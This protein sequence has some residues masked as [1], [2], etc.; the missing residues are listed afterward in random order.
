MK[1]IQEIDNNLN[2]KL[3][4]SNERSF[5]PYTISV[6]TSLNT[7]ILSLFYIASRRSSYPIMK[8]LKNNSTIVFQKKVKIATQYNIN[9]EFA[10]AVFDLF[11][12]KTAYYDENSGCYAILG[13]TLLE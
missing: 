8:I 10:F 9:E 2:W 11:L 6:S 12:N 13:Y 4:R 5:L 1:P 3:F 7:Y